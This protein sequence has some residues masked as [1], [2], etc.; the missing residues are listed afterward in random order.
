MAFSLSRQHL[1]LAQQ[2]DRFWKVRISPAPCILHLLAT[3]VIPDPNFATH[4]SAFCKVFSPILVYQNG[5]FQAIRAFLAN[6]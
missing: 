4:S 5:D 6:P 2:P 1:F 3:I